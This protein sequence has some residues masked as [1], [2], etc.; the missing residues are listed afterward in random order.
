MNQHLRIPILAAAL[1][2]SAAAAAA[3]VTYKVDPR[4]TFPSFEADHFGGMSVW[5]GK[6]NETSGTIV[7]DR[8][9]QSGSIDIRIAM[10]SVDTGQDDL[11]KHLRSDEFFDVA[12]FPAATYKGRF[13]KLKCMPHP[14]K[15]KKEFCGADASATFNR[16]EFGIVWGKD[17][18]FAMDVKLAIQVE[19]DPG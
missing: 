11:N 14:M 19:T 8:A 3:P 13:G 6:F 7:L 17:F 4:H 9:A 18:G 16:E 2:L 15:A 10:A 12:K 5:R 1:A